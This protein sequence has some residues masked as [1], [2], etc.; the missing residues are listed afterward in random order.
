MLSSDARNRLA[1]LALLCLTL[2]LAADEQPLATG[3]RHL[4]PVAATWQRLQFAGE[5][6]IGSVVT[7]L[8]LSPATHADLDAPPYSELQDTPD[9]FDSDQP[10]RLEVNGEVRSLFSRSITLASAWFDPTTGQVLLRERTR[11]GR[12][13][14]SKIHRFGARGV[15]RLR[16]EPADSRQAGLPTTRWSRR[17]RK[18]YPYDLQDSGC[19]QIT[20]PALLLYHVS[21]QLQ[22]S[23]YCV[24]H[25]DSLYRVRLES[26]GSKVLSVDYTVHSPGRLQQISGPRPLEH[27]ALHVEPLGKQADVGDF[28]LLELRGELAIQLDPQTR[29]PVQVSG[30]RAGLGDITLRLIDASAAAETGRRR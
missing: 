6:L 20:I 23:V 7:T 22:D 25:D 15:A 28:E 18:F 19:S 4:P 16:L 11:P 5:D 3:S 1:A 12:K 26:T 24:F 27:I 29:I 30:S 2:P 10:L 8:K 17:D 21:S 13:G 14:T 9:A